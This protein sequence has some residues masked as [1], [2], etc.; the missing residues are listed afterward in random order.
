ML[1]F[2]FILFTPNIAPKIQEAFYDILANLDRYTLNINLTLFEML[3]SLELLHRTFHLARD[4]V[5]S[6]LSL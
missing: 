2:L 6:Y 4:N 5:K 3:F 1:M